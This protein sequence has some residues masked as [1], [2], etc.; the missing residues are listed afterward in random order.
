MS[1]ITVKKAEENKQNEI[2]LNRAMSR[3][4][5]SKPPRKSSRRAGNTAEQHFDHA[6]DVNNFNLSRFASLLIIMRDDEEANAALIG[7]GQTLTRSQ[8]GAGFMRQTLSG[9]VESRFTDPFLRYFLDM[10][11]G[12]DGVDSRLHRRP[13]AQLLFLRTSLMA[14]RGISPHICTIGQPP[15]RTIGTDLGGISLSSQVANVV[16]RGSA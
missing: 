13:I 7:M 8:L 2:A 15:V 12:V 5:P 4:S 16:H 11:G 1:L 3:L 14:K 9:V 10:T 6:G